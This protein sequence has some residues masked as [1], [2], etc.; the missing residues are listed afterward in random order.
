MEGIRTE[1]LG[2]VLVLRMARGKTNALNIS[3]VEELNAAIDTAASDTEVRGL[4]LASDCPGFFSCGFDVSE[5]FSYDRNN[6]TY[7]LGRFI[8]LYEGLYLLPKPAVAAIS[9]YA[10]AGGAMLAAACDFRVMSEEGAD[11]ALSEID[12]GLMLPPGFLRML[13]GAAGFIAAR[14]IV[15]TGAVVLPQR[16]REIGL[17]GELVEPSMVRQR[18]VDLCA[19]LAAKPETAFAADKREL[20]EIAG[21]TVSNSD[22]T[23]LQQ[24]IEVWFSPEVEARKQSL[25]GSL[26]GSAG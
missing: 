24:M 3:L 7:F 11:F 13:T 12:L 23:C 16:A 18:A 25:I 17:V 19:S 5:V 20:R 22:R 6:M 9:G 2:G 26:R 1:R 14:D 10:R 8:D 15:L 21:R 4:V